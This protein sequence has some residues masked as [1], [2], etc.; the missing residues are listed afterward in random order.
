MAATPAGGGCH[1]GAVVLQ[2]RG[3]LRPPINCHCGLCRRL[4]GAAF[5][6]W[7]SVPVEVLLVQGEAELVSYRP[8]PNLQRLFCRHCGTHVLTRDARCQHIAGLPAGVMADA[9]VPAPS[10]EYFTS[11]KAPWYSLPA[12][13]PCFGGNTGVEPLPRPFDAGGTRSRDDDHCHVL[14]P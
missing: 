14:M 9:D 7:L 10:G 2:I 1:C 6:T 5:T 8:T 4:S 3:T 11:H 13:A 12:S